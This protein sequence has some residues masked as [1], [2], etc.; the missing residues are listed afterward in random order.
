MTHTGHAGARAQGHTDHTDEPHNHPNPPTHNPHVSLR[1]SATT[2]AAADSNKLEQPANCHANSQLQ[3]NSR[4]AGEPRSGPLPQL[5]SPQPTQKTRGRPL[6]TGT[7]PC[8][9]PLP[10]A[11]SASPRLLEG[12]LGEMKARASD[13]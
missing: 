7:R 1:V 9:L 2:E 11:E 3:P 12:G 4:R 13:A 6:R 5:R 8:R 10:E